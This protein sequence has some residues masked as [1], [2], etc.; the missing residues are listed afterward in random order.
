MLRSVCENGKRVTSSPERP[1]IYSWHSSLAH[2]LDVSRL[3]SI[4]I[5]TRRMSI[6]CLSRT[7][8]DKLYLGKIHCALFVI[9]F[10]TAPPAFPTSFVSFPFLFN[11]LYI[12][13]YIYFFSSLLQKVL[14]VQ[15][16]WLHI[17]AGNRA[18]DVC[19]PCLLLC[20]HKETL[21]GYVII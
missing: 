2:A 5:D 8:R 18:S 21:F 15:L 14:L 1:T 3:F 13:I 4:S 19:N 10:A 17:C 6:S 11:R 9:D 12:D 16:L 7:Q 20:K